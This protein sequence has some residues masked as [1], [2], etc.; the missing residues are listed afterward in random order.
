MGLIGSAGAKKAAQQQAK[1]MKEIAEGYGKL[2]QKQYDWISP[3]M[4]A[5]TEALSAEMQMLANP[6]NS[7][8]ALNDYYAGPQYAQEQA[9]AQYAAEAGAEATGGLGNT[10]TSN[11][12]AS[13]ST[14][15]GQQYLQGLGKARA[16]EFS[17]L[18]GISNQGL[19]ATKQMGNWGFQDYNAAASYLGQA[20]GL[21]GQATMAPYSGMQQAVKGGMGLYGMGSMMKSAGADTSLGNNLGKAAMTAMMF[22]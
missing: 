11:I 14:Q 16:Q 6:M 9:E 18:S 2:G 10:A 17:Q 20:A 3:W 19:S 15:L 13:Q 7:Q 21:E 12:L 8:A 22:L 1:A 5:G 4:N